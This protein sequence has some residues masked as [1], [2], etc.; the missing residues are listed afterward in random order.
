MRM[1]P[2]NYVTSLVAEMDKAVH[3]YSGSAAKADGNQ[4]IA[5]HICVVGKDCDGRWRLTRLYSVTLVWTGLDDAL[6]QPFDTRECKDR[7]DIESDED[8]LTNNIMTNRAATVMCLQF[9][10]PVSHST[11]SYGK[12]WLKLQSFHGRKCRRSALAVRSATPKGDAQ[13]ADLAAG[14]VCL[15]VITG[16]RRTCL[17]STS[18][19]SLSRTEA[20]D[21]R[22]AVNAEGPCCPVQLLMAEHEPW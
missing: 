20:T 18:R 6:L 5:R 11:D 8:L 17:A 15:T 4:K 19:I 16:C 14:P 3:V 1:A 10:P 21:L 12:H 22:E 7:L 13:H 9:L 2:R